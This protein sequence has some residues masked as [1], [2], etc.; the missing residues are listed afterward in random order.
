[1][2]PA[3]LLRRLSS[4]RR[5]EA[6]ALEAQN[7]VL[8]ELMTARAEGRGPEMAEIGKAMGV[9]RQTAHARCARA[10]AEGRD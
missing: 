6:R 1:M 9:S 10:V 5:A 7:D 8:R 4:L 3:Q 2:D